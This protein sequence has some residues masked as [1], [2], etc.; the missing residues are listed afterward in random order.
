MLFN[1]AHHDIYNE[2]IKSLFLCFLDL[3]IIDSYNIHTMNEKKFLQILGELPKK[4]NLNSRILEERDCGNYLMQKIEFHAEKNDKI[5]AYILIPKNINKKTPAIYCHHQHASNWE[6][7]KS[8]IVGLKG[9]PDMAYAVELAEAGFITFAPDAIA[10][11][12]RQ[13]KI[14]GANGNYLELAQR[15]VNGKNLLSKTLFDISLGID[16]LQSR[17]E[18]DSNKI[19]FI[20]HSYGGRMAIFAP[21]FDKRIKAS[22]SNC[23]CINYKDSIKNKIGIQMEFCV[24][25]IL[26]YGD[27]EDIVKLV[28]PCSLLISATKEDKYS[29]GALKI[30]E[31]AKNSFKDSEI[32]VKVYPGGHIF[33]KEMRIFAFSFLKK[34]LR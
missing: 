21:A 6:I 17:E 2:K 32:L 27:V 13:N 14:G 18:V 9:D 28:N 10:F 26:H 29:I 5:P 1:T 3:Y 16:Y 25:N 7:G 8:E 24:P 12:E 23:G 20:G 33:T 31:Y 4:T 22:V 19:G 11:E 34:H 30:L 15:I